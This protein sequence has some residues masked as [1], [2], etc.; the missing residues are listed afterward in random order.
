[1]H[2]DGRFPWEKVALASPD[3]EVLPV[4][5]DSVGVLRRKKSPEPVAPAPSQGF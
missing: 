4:R 1:V 5:F 2:F 3:Y